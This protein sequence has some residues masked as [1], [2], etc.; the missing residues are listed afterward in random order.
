MV[1]FYPKK[2][3][4]GSTVERYVRNIVSKY[5]V[6]WSNRFLVIM[7]EVL[8]KVISRKTR[9]KFLFYIYLHV[10][11]NAFEAYISENKQNFE[12]SFGSLIF[13]K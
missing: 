10:I 4:L 1:K 6:I 12:K 2:L 13:D 7:A 5:E 9:L 8:K 3:I 11:I